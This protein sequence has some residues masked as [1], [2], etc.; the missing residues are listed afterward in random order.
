M[1]TLNKQLTAWDRIRASGRSVLVSL[2]LVDSEPEVEAPSQPQSCPTCGAAEC[3]CGEAC[4]AKACGCCDACKATASEP[5]SE[6]APEPA[7]EDPAPAPE[8]DPAPVTEPCP[9]CG[10]PDCACGDNCTAKG[11]ACCE[12]CAATVEE[13]PP[14]EPPAEEPA[15]EQSAALV[16]ALRENASLKAALAAKETPN[17]QAEK[18]KRVDAEVA[19][20]MKDHGARMGLQKR[21]VFTSVLR[22][23]KLGVVSLTRLK[24]G[25]AKDAPESER[26]ETLSAPL[27]ARASMILVASLE[28]MAGVEPLPGAEHRVQAGG[29]RVD[30]EVARVA[31]DK[32]VDADATRDAKVQARITEKQYRGANAYAKAYAEIVAEESRNV[33]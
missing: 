20:F 3:Q 28:A 1:T 10:S 14:A 2:Q 27:S 9:T 26:S 12:A 30:A 4:T 33:G 8:P 31:G 24:A 13:D 21:E 29:P 18:T 16:A 22:N 7:S 11:C 15:P 17:L 19:A 6:P 5:V 23:A 25:V 32:P